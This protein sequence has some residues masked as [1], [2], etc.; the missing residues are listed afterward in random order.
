LKGVNNNPNLVD[1]EITGIRIENPVKVQPNNSIFS[2]TDKI[3]NE[4]NLK[5]NCLICGN[6]GNVFCTICSGKGTVQKDKQVRTPVRKSRY[7]TKYKYDYKGNRVSYSELEYYTDY[8]NKTE[9]Y[10]ERCNNCV[11]TGKVKCTNIVAHP[12]KLTD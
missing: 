11:G 2:G 9:Y 5:G 8:E 12:I 4:T 6:K 3:K 7:V 1:Y 10:N